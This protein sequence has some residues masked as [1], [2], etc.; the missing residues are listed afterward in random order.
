VILILILLID[1]FSFLFV[2]DEDE[3]A[4]FGLIII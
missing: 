3:V 1:A 4:S 2:L